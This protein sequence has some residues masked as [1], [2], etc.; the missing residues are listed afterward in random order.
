[1]RLQ[2]LLE[3]DDTLIG[4]WLVERQETAGTLV[5]TV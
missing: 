3:E 2:L 1:M 4:R 5:E